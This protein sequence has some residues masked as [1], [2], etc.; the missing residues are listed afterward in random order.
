[1]KELTEKQRNVL[2][3]IR[4]YTEEKLCPPTVREVA[5]NFSVSIKAI[6]DHIAALRKKG[7]LA[8]S[9][10]KSRSLRIV[11]DDGTIG[12]AFPK[13]HNVPILGSVAAGRP[14]FCD[15]NYLGYYPLPEPYAQKDKQYFALRVQGLSMKDAGILDGDIGIF[16]KSETA[17]NGQIVVAFFD[18]SVT[19]KRFFKEESRIRLQP[20]NPDFNPIYLQDVKILGVLSSIIRNY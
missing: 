3:F 10:K 4:V 17:R 19:L 1:M 16:E 9:E 15:E 18:E 5:E 20:E 12:N 2:R 13:F 14:I 7:Y 6:Q 8:A 11:L